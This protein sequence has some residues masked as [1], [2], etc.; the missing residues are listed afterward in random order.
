M[1]CTGLVGGVEVAWLRRGFERS[2]D[3]TCWI[4]PQ[5]KGLPVEKRGLRQDFLSVRRWRAW[6]IE[7]HLAYRFWLHCRVANTV[8]LTNFGKRQEPGDDGFSTPVLI[9]AI[10]MKSIAA[11]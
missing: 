6:R 8:E 7:T 5:I 1:V 3:D 11:T 2:H 10:G 9:G 4:R